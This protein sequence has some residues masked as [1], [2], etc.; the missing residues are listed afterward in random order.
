MEN[1]VPVLNFY[2]GHG[3]NARKGYFH[4]EP[5]FALSHE[6]GQLARLGG[7]NDCRLIPD[8]I[9]AL[10]A[11]ASH[12]WQ[13]TLWLE[14]ERD[15]EREFSG[16]MRGEY[17]DVSWTGLNPSS[18][19]YQGRLFSQGGHIYGLNCHARQI[20]KFR[21][22]QQFAGPSLD[23]QFVDAIT[24][25]PPALDSQDSL[26]EY[27][28]FFNTYGTHYVT[29]GTLGGMIF[30]ETAIKIPAAG[31]HELP[32]IG[33]RLNL[34]FHGMLE[35]NTFKAGLENVVAGP[36]DS[37]DQAPDNQVDILGGRHIFDDGIS[38]WA[39]S[40]HEMPALLLLGPQNSRQ[41]LSSLAPLSALAD[42]AGAAWPVAGCMRQA[43]EAYLAPPGSAGADVA[44]EPALDSAA[45]RGLHAHRNFMAAL[46]G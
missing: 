23:P 40:I 12:T 45:A 31:H 25:L 34:A 2:A 20:M 35:S 43:L 7:E 13:D 5:V 30:M 21:R 11:Q 37:L 42:A 22:V 6:K 38:G 44:L 24:G 15:Y 27:F 28:C 33:K 26:Q 29:E 18:L 19:L 1:T 41:A 9:S 4:G 10:P 39:R 8:Q 32:E 3:Y 46:R 14:N 36:A 16:M 17:T